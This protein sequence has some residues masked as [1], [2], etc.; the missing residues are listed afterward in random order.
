MLGV[1]HPSPSF[2]ESGLDC[3][4]VIQTP[5][6]NHERHQTCLTEDPNYIYRSHVLRMASSSSA[7]ANRPAQNIAVVRK[8]EETFEERARREQ[9]ARFLESN[10]LL[11]WLSMSRNEV[12]SPPSFPFQILERPLTCHLSPCRRPGTTTSTSWPTS[13][14]T[15]RSS[16]RTCTSRLLRTASG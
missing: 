10:E 11:M 7:R 14:P 5:Q 2:W 12:L 8:D 3:S 9:A 6:A 4:S 16:G 13:T 15:R 1:E